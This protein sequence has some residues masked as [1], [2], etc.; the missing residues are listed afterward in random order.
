MSEKKFFSPFFVCLENFFGLCP[1]KKSGD[2]GREKILITK[3]N[4]AP[5]QIKYVLPPLNAN[6]C[7]VSFNSC[8]MTFLGSFQKQ[9]K[10]SKDKNFTRY[11]DQIA[12]IT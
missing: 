10:P 3:K 2:G 9:I 5:P 8:M 1:K 6:S 12:K 11:A 7:R 4:L